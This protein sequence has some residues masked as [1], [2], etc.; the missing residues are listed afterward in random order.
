MPA[1]LSESG[2]QIFCSATPAALAGARVA[3]WRAF[4]EDEPADALGGMASVANGTL[5]LT[6]GTADEASIGHVRFAPTRPLQA[7]V[8]RFLLRGEICL[9][10]CTVFL[11]RVRFR[12]V[13]ARKAQWSVPRLGR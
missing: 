3:L 9:C 11:V 2:S 5:Q 13:F 7:F 8:A 1:T 12:C 6:N 4:R 10:G